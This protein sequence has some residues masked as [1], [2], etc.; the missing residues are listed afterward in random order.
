MLNLMFVLTKAVIS[1]GCPMSYCDSALS[2]RQYVTS[3]L[4]KQPRVLWKTKNITGGGEGSL[5]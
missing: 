1:N 2:S 3:P 4:L 5:I